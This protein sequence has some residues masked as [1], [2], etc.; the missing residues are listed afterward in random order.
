MNGNSEKIEQAG[1][2]TNFSGFEEEDIDQILDKLKVYIP[3]AETSQVIAW[4]DSIEVLKALVSSLQDPFKSL[5]NHSIILEYKIP[6]EQR[7]IDAL[8]LLADTAIVLEFKGK[9]TPTRADM[10]Q[11]ISCLLYTSPSPRDTERSRMP[12]SA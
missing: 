5:P 1:Y 11:A 6:W 4:K 7:R 12:S 2:F 8:L 9:D 10:D 3:D